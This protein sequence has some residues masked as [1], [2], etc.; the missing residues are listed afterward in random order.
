MIS[1]HSIEAAYCFFHQKWRVYQYSDSPQQK[2]EIEFAIASYVESMNQD[3]Y[4]LLAA[5]RNDFLLSHA[6]FAADIAAS[7]VKLEEML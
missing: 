4:A 2:E 6:S 1:K 5:G 7:V 3:L